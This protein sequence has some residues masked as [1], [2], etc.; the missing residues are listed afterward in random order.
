M[1]G[2]AIQGY[3]LSKWALAK[4]GIILLSVLS[5]YL[6]YL[7]YRDF[8]SSV[9]AYRGLT[10]VSLTYV[11]LTWS[12]AVG[13]L[14]SLV[15]PLSIR[16]PGEL[17]LWYIYLVIVL[18][19]L[20]VSLA[21]DRSGEVVATGVVGLLVPF[22]LLCIL[23]NRTNFYFLK[24]G[25]EFIS[26]KSYSFIA[27]FLAIF[28]SIS[29]L[30][31]FRNYLNFS[32]ID[33]YDRRMQARDI[34]ES[35]SILAYS[36][37]FL[38]NFIIPVCVACFWFLDKG[39]YLVLLVGCLSA[40]IIFALDGTKSILLLPALILIVGFYVNKGRLSPV[41]ISCIMM[42]SLAV[43]YSI[44]Y[45]FDFNFANYYFSR[46][47]FIVPVWL[48]NNYIEY[49]SV[50]EY[51]F[52]R[53]V[54]FVGDLFGGG[55]ESAAMLVGENYMGVDGA[56]AN[57]GSI[58]Y[59]YSEWGIFGCWIVSLLVFLYLKTFD[60]LTSGFPASVAFSLSML[61]SFKFTEQ[62]FHT[63]LVTGGLGILILTLIFVNSGK[64]KRRHNRIHE[65]ESR[66][67]V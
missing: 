25:I 63:S 50:G 4:F 29:F 23:Y 67:L 61:I 37:A 56:N 55:K 13:A 7:I 39:K 54:K 65:N 30:V 31:I 14:L 21:Q 18:P 57:V 6:L 28:I 32:F 49:F 53:D 42:I 35:G 46:R 34:L 52:F 12:I 3:D 16:K 1:T 22:S 5:Q 59:G 64:L 60:A 66:V 40:S 19:Y 10:F 51:L 17:V 41:W 15:L 62:A 33:I 47:L 36:S 43:A 9:E 48:Y 58:Q 8:V 38:G 45:A 11:Q 2:S 27:A 26:L 24:E 20:P 44:D